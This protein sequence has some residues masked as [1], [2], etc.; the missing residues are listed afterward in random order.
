MAK[1]QSP[2][3]EPADRRQAGNTQPGTGAIRF[4]ERDYTLLDCMRLGRNGN[5]LF[6]VFIIICLI[7][8]YSFAKYGKY[9]IPF[10]IVAYTAETMG[11]ALFT[12]SII[13]IDKLVRARGLMKILMPFYIFV[14]AVLMLL[15]FDLLP[16][17]PYNGLALDLIISHAL[18]SAVIALSLLQLDPQ[19]KKMQLTV[20][21]TCTICLA[22]MLPGIAGNRVYTSILINAFAYIVFF[23]IMARLI[24]TEE[25]LIDCHGDQAVPT[26][27]STTMFTD[28]PLLQEPAPKRQKTLRQ[29]AREAADSL[30]SDE[31][32]ILTDK[33]EKFEYEFGVQEDDD[34]DEYE[35]D[36]R[37]GGEDPRR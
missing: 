15:E 30:V 27:F 12:L 2:K 32:V 18:F 28:S 21:I 33:E 35:D 25:I 14:E 36:D 3:T 37:D 22:G 10:E 26:K 4:R 5:I 13:W 19:N 1:K 8:Y 23:S 34:D 6:V 11:F 17:I 24:Q 9:F 16:F 7:Y 31:K 20:G 29:K